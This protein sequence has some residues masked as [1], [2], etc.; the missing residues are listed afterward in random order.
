[1]KRCGA[2]RSGTSESGKQ[3][4]WRNFHFVDVFPFIFVHRNYLEFS[5]L[6][7]ETDTGRMDEWFTRRW[8]DWMV[9]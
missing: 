5:G 7:R 1:M 9:D 3:T 8:D 6:D 2:V 4:K